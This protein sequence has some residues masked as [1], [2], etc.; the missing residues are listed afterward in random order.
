VE[1]KRRKEDQQRQCKNGGIPLPGLRSV[2]WRAA[3]S[4]RQLAEMAGVGANTVRLLESGSRGAYPT[5]VRKLAA[6]LGVAPEELVRGHH[7]E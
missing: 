7:R 6:A 3:L 1:G 4:Q 5:T 2:R